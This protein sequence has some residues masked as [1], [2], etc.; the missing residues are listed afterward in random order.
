[1]SDK[2]SI[3]NLN[4]YCLHE[5]MSHLSIQ[6]LMELELT[7]SIFGQ[8]TP[9]F[10]KRCSEWRI[11]N[12]QLEV[13]PEWIWQKIE[14]YVVN[15]KLAGFNTTN[16][17]L[18]KLIDWFPEV[19]QLHLQDTYVQKMPQMPKRLQRLTLHNSC[20]KER[21]DDDRWMKDISSTL[22]QIELLMCPS[23]VMTE[24]CN[25]PYWHLNRIKH[26]KFKCTNLESDTLV[27]F[28]RN[29]RHCLESL[30]LDH[31]INDFTEECYQSLSELREVTSLAISGDI[32]LK[33]VSESFRAQIKSLKLIDFD[34]FHLYKAIE[35]LFPANH[36]EYLTA[37]RMCLND[38][39]RLVENMPD[40]KRIH[41]TDHCHPIAKLPKVVKT[42]TDMLQSQERKFTI[43]LSCIKVDFNRKQFGDFLVIES[44]IKK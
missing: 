1:M 31:A 19:E 4:Y 25:V 37:S 13:Y 33:S 6:N 35:Y 15:L 32:A 39:P 23:R 29:N 34:I 7:N 42:L 18:E 2:L 8:I 36:L 21:C 11:E 40:L 26:A 28:L 38:I 17:A 3:K 44:G 43:Y 10:Y 24:Q 12:Y 20:I 22:T 41:I 30:E 27:E 5:I 9:Y 16:S 14:Q